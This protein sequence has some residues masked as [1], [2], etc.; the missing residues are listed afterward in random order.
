[1][2]FTLLNYA[3]DSVMDEYNEMTKFLLTGVTEMNETRST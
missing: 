1:M 2:Y 3:V